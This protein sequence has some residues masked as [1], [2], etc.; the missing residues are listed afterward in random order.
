MIL[1]T[2]AIVLKIVKFGELHLIFSCFTKESGL[3][4][5]FQKNAYQNKKKISNKV[6][7]LNKIEIDF[8]NQQNK[9][10]KTVKSINNAQKTLFVEQNVFQSSIS[11]FL[12][13]IVMQCIR[14]AQKDERIYQFLNQEIQKLSDLKTNYGNFSWQ[15]LLNF[16]AYLGFY[17]N[18]NDFEKPHFDLL[19]GIFSDEFQ[20]NSLNKE[21]SKLWKRMLKFEDEHFSRFERQQIVHLLLL[22]YSIH[23]QNFKPPKS[24]SILEEVFN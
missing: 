21:D 13:E 24:L 11:L 9:E 8:L 18:D 5:F 7:P 4:T 23:V 14:E 12:S 19:H 17:P 22:F 3:I 15:F 1:S 16:S 20:N 10:L 2:E 6:F